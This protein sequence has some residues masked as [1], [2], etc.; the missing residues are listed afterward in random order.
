MS[1]KNVCEG[2]LEKGK[3]ENGGGERLRSGPALLATQ[4]A[5]RVGADGPEGVVAD[6]RAG[7]QKH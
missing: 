7:H 6:A 4:D 5:G 1:G 3:L 2:K